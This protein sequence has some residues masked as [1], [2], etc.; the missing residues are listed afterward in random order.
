M[1]CRYLLPGV[2]TSC[3]VVC[4]LY[5]LLSASILLR[6]VHSS[7]APFGVPEAIVWVYTHMTT[8]PP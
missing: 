8:A 6:G 1:R 5:V 2:R 7:M 4:G 3:L